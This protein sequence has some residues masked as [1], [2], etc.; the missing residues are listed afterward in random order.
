ML[1]EG[2]IWCKYRKSYY[3][4]YVCTC[5]SSKDYMRAVSD[6]HI[7]PGYTDEKQE[8]AESKTCE[9]C[10]YRNRQ[11]ICLNCKSKYFDK[12]VDS[13]KWCEWWKGYEQKQD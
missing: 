7:C 6:F 4:S 2:C 9:N 1:I 13:E 8:E 5:I 3:K 11:D 10:Y 12:W